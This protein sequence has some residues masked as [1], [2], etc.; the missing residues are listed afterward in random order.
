[1]AVF[2]AA[3][4]AVTLT[5]A[6]RSEEAF[7]GRTFGERLRRVSRR[8]VVDDGARRFS[9]R[10]AMANREHRAVRRACVAAV[11]LTGVLEGERIMECFGGQPEP[12]Q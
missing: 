10:S 9:L 8:G 3:Y 4:L 2:I 1:M 12:V 11:L 6:I 7:L 5:A